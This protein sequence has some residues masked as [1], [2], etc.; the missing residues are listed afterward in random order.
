[1]PPLTA[2]AAGRWLHPAMPAASSSS[3]AILPRD[4][5]MLWTQDQSEQVYRGLLGGGGPDDGP[6]SRCPPLAGAQLGQAALA[7]STVHGGEERGRH[8]ADEHQRRERG[9]LRI[10]IES[11]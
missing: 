1:M 11:W 9:R 4:T 8:P 3:T 6:H 2:G 7:H 10:G 5:G